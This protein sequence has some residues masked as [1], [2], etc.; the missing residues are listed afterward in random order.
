MA[1]KTENTESEKTH[2]HE[3]CCCD[4]HNAHH[5]HHHH[6]NHAGSGA[7]YGL[8]LVG[9]LVYFLSQAANFET[10]LIGVLK[11]LVWPAYLVYDALKFF[12]H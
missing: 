7:V 9:A 3:E 6:N 11:A 12:I 4:W 1:D 8:G 5:H 2:N 10:G